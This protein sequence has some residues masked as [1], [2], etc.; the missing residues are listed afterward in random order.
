MTISQLNP[1][2]ETNAGL[3]DLAGLVGPGTGHSGAGAIFFLSVGEIEDRK[4]KPW[5][6]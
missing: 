2:V 6:G 1:W 3:E 4:K 5:F